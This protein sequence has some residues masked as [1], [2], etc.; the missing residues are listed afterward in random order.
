LASVG[1]GLLFNRNVTVIPEVLVPFSAGN[2]D[3]LFSIKVLYS[4]GR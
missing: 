4:F 2:G 3:A 1:A